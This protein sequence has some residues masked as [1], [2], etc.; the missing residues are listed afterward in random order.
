MRAT[1][2][3]IRRSIGAAPVRKSPATADLVRQMLD[4]CRD[5]LRGKRDRALL[6]LGF[7]GAFRRSELV[8][9]RVEDLAP[10]PDGLRVTIRRSKTDQEGLGQTVAILRGPRLRPVEAVE[11]W[12]EAGATVFKL[13]EVSRHRSVDMLAVYVPARPVS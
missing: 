9:P 4:A 2:R 8:A 11:R 1:V 6:A 13:M 12:V 10:T 5:T 7:A 3:G